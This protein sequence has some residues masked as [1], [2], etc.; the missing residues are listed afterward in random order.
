VCWRGRVC[1]SGR[2]RHLARIDDTSLLGNQ[3]SDGAR[4]RAD[5]TRSTGTRTRRA[6]PR[7]AVVTGASGM[8]LKEWP[9]AAATGA[10]TLYV[11]GPP[12]NFHVA[13]ARAAA[14]AAVARRLP[15]PSDLRLRLHGPTTRHTKTPTQP[16]PDPD[17][18]WPNDCARSLSDE[19]L[20]CGQVRIKRLDHLP[21]I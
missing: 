8:I 20:V 11:C 2:P 12:Y 19:S 9:G 18:S 1:H 7:P 3:D 17:E 5:D 14:R 4:Y 15:S 10:N 6:T 16:D 13:P 21:G